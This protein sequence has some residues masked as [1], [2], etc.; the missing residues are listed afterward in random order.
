MK[1]LSKMR[2][3]KP[4]KDLDAV[5][6]KLHGIGKLGREALR[7]RSRIESRSLYGPK[8]LE[9]ELEKIHEKCINFLTKVIDLLLYIVFAFCTYYSPN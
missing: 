9:L 4:R 1:S 7:I 6:T 2:G 5:K 8:E 3:H